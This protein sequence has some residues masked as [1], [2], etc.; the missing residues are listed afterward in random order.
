MCMRHIVI[1]GLS[2]LYNIF[3]HYL[4]KSTIFFWGGGL[5]KNA[6]FDFFYNSCLKHFSFYEELGKTRSKM[7]IGFHVK[8][9]LFLSNFNET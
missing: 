8:Y 6:C 5:N 7:Y 4:I 3:P 1:C 9:R 2:S